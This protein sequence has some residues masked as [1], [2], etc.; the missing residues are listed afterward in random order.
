MIMMLLRVKIMAAMIMIMGFLITRV[1]GRKSGR[2][3]LDQNLVSDECKFFFVLF[4][5]ELK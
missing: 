4:R 2:M 1:K 3:K 5:L